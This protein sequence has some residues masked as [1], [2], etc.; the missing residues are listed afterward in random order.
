MDPTILC[1]SIGLTLHWQHP[2]HISRRN[3]H[4]PRPRVVLRHVERWWGCGMR[5]TWHVSL[6]KKLRGELLSRPEGENTPLYWS[7]YFTMVCW[8]NFIGLSSERGFTQILYDSDAVVKM[9][10]HNRT[11]FCSPMTFST[12]HR[13]PAL[14]LPLSSELESGWPPTLGLFPANQC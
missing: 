6:G 9:E 4:P 10:S 14:V 12:L 8:G 1:N 5:S 13:E 11:E 7:C 2:F 3:L